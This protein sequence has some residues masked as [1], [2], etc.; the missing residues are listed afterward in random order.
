MIGEED[1]TVKT[2]YPGRRRRPATPHERKTK[3]YMDRAPAR[4]ERERMLFSQLAF[5]A[6]VCE[7]WQRVVSDVE[8]PIVVSIAKAVSL[9]NPK[10]KRLFE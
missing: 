10:V 4:T 9:E 7:V 5:V 6:S 3:E 1:A 8:R 2:T